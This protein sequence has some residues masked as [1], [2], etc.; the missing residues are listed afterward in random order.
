LNFAQLV[1][2]RS[3]QAIQRMLIMSPA[4]RRPILRVMGISVGKR[5]RI[6]GGVEIFSGNI[7]FGERSFVN[8][9]CF[10][11]ASARITI[12]ARAQL[13]PRV[14]LLTSSHEI[15]G[16]E[17]RAGPLYALPITIG[18]GAW[19]GG[20]SLILPGAVVGAGCIIAAGAVVRGETEPNTVYAGVPARKVK[21]LSQ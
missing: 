20:G 1:A 4:L 12:G 8:T 11:D 7:T 5:A 13:G 15:G 18:D 19:I 10:F 21:D 2:F 3:A 16:P 6:K 14:T 17:Q 9:G